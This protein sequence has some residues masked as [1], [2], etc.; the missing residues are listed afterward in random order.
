MTTLRLIGICFLMG[1]S[2][3][4]AQEWENLFNGKDLSGWKQLNGEAPYTVEDGMI[5]GTTI[6]NTPNSFLATEKTYGDFILE[7]EIKL[8]S[9]NTGVQI[10][11]LSKP[12]YN[13]GRVHGYQVEVDP[14]NRRWT[15]GIYDEARR[16]WLYPL[17]QNPPAR[18]AFRPKGWNHIRVEAI[19]NSIRT[20]LNGVPAADLIDDM[21]AE[22]FIA[23]QVHSVSG[24]SEAGKKIRWRNVR[25]QTKN[26]Q[27]S[28][29]T[30]IPVVNLIPNYLSPQERAQGWE[31]LFD[32]KSTRGWRGAG[33]DAFPKGGWKVEKG[34]LVVEA[35]DG[36]E[37]TN[38]GDIVTA[39]EYQMFEFK[40]DFK[41][42]EGAN[43]GIKYYITESYGSNASA[44]GL[45]Y[46]LLD[47]ERHP[48][49]KKGKNGNRTVGSLYDL[50]PASSGKDVK[51]PGQWNQ[52]RLVVHGIR[53]NDIPNQAFKKKAPDQ[54]VGAYVEHW[55][56][57]KLILTYE[58]GN[59]AFDALVA[60]SKYEKWEGFGHWQSGHILLQDHGDEVRFRSIKV[61]RL[62]K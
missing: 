22:G 30:D 25:I 8:D 4:F 60:R 53:M 49:A 14:S 16:G 54:F 58:R 42:S 1:Y 17:E 61:R 45:E 28:A 13:N 37:S 20:W 55:L 11:S 23:L 51:K 35:S 48:D 31:L 36:G 19:G 56:N 40:V 33:K 21:T 47:D 7:F 59:Q 29:W 3:L 24:P 57:G 12:D 62:S 38:G 43:S 39:E 15:A 9:T 32:G 34:E 10:R 50:I 26:L 52:A 2:T 46:Q 18:A 41:L 27:R 5:V 44:I 6:A